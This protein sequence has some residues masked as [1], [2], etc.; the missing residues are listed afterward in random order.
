MR[1][2]LQIIILSCST[3]FFTFFNQ[4]REP[5]PHLSE[6]L[7]CAVKF[8]GVGDDGGKPLPP[9]SGDEGFPAWGPGRARRCRWPLLLGVAPLPD[10]PVTR[11][12]YQIEWH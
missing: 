9:D 2:D 7:Y 4:T 10:S 1:N 3:W 5:L 8:D 11:L 12:G 6:L